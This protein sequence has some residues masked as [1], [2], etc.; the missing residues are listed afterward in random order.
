IMHNNNKLKCAH[1]VHGGTVSYVKNIINSKLFFIK[2]II[3]CRSFC[4][5]SSKGI[6]PT[7][8]FYKTSALYGIAILSNYRKTAAEYLEL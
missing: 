1:T 8:Y 7:G 5:R 4:D 6:V 2:I 3:V